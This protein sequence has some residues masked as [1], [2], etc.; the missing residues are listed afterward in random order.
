MA[1]T[2]KVDISAIGKVIFYILEMGQN[3]NLGPVSMVTNS[4]LSDSKLNI[5]EMD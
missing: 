3:I 2:Q 4:A 5:S 1:I